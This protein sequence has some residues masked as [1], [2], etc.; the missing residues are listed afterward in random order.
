MTREQRRKW[1]MLWVA[2]FLC[3]GGLSEVL[4]PGHDQYMLAASAIRPG[5]QVGQDVHHTIVGNTSFEALLPTLL[6][7]REV[8]ASLMWV[9]ADDY[10]HRGEYRPIIS[11]VKQIVAID[12]HQLD[13]YATGAWHMAYN[14]MD[15]RLIE[16]GV[17]F[18]EDGCKNNDAVYDLYFELGYMHYDKTKDWKKSVAAYQESSTRGTTTGKSEPPSYVRHQL[19]HALEKMG[20]IDACI[21]RWK[22]NLAIARKLEDSGERANQVSGPNTSAARHNLYITTRRANERLASNAERAGNAAE[23]LKMW[24][25]NVDLEKEWLKEFPN[26][27]AVTDDLKNAEAQVERLKSGKL[28]PVAMTD[29]DFQFKVT[30]LAPRRIQVE[31]TC[32][33]LN[34]A[35]VR[36]QFADQDYDARAAKGFDFKMDNCSLEWDN[37]PVNK[38]HFK[39]VF[40]LAK[41]PGEMGRDPSDVYPLK[42]DKYDISVTFN[43]RLQAAFIQDIYG[44]DGEGMTA[45][46]EYIKY[47]DRFPG[48][49]YGKTYPLKL[50]TKTV[51]IT[52]DQVTGKG[53]Q[54]LVDRI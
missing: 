22:E 8:L 19:A 32:N 48:K 10:F 18:L 50:V 14:F 9:R 21:E 11:M 25:A 51:T 5:D 20:D 29:L 16:N 7:I 53:T 4:S 13:V 6:G 44:W 43:P 2:V 47:D 1:W 28:Q 52:R 12:P 34:L 41:D 42:A 38:S 15:K 39:H 24:Q 54:V 37:V 3:V 46:P 26:H 31:G 30:R 36:V 45:K 27:G 35:R 33:A 23:A 49:I 17:E 40:E